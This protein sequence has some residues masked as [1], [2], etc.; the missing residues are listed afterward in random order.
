MSDRD[1]REVERQYRESPTQETLGRLINV[2]ARHG[3]LI[4]LVEVAPS[5]STRDIHISPP[6]VEMAHIEDDPAFGPWGLDDFR[7][8]KAVYEIMPEVFKDAG[9]EFDPEKLEFGAS[10]LWYITDNF[11]EARI[12]VDALSELGLPNNTLRATK[13][14]VFS[15]ELDAFIEANEIPVNDRPWEYFPS[16]IEHQ[17]YPEKITPAEVLEDIM[18]D[19][20]PPTAPAWTIE[21][22][23]RLLTHPNST[24][25][26][27]INEPIPSLI[28]RRILSEQ[29][30]VTD[31]FRYVAYTQ[32]DSPSLKLVEAGYIPDTF[33]RYGDINV[34][35]RE[36]LVALWRGGTR[37][38]YPIGPEQR[39]VASVHIAEAPT[40]AWINE[41]IDGQYSSGENYSRENALAELTTTLE[42]HGIWSDIVWIPQRH[43]NV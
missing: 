29:Q 24:G 7:N 31:I 22:Q 41:I 1:I 26:L 20:T 2:Y 18:E 38:I 33:C 17:E 9:L 28:N 6:R 10:G 15:Q 42:R 5:I 19:E 40:E 34:D 43:W 30:N 25:H 11:A 37:M 21:E 3:I 8:P 36:I 32:L 13:T 39:F 4:N 27:H 23:R 16:G 14:I 12:T 35:D